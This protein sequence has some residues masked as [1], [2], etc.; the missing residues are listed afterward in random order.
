MENEK[1]KKEVL[2]LDSIALTYQSLKG[3]TP[4]INDVSLTVYE[5]EIV[6]IV[7]PSGCGKT[8]LLSI[9]AGLIKPSNGSVRIDNEPVTTKETIKNRVGYMF[10][11]DHLFEWRTVWE[12]VILAFEINKTKTKENL[13]RVERLLK[14]YGLYDFKDKHPRELSGG[15]RQRV[16]LIRTL[17]TNPSVLLLD[18]PFS[19]LDYQTRIKVCDDV[20][21]IIKNENKTAVLVTHDIAESICLANKVVVLTKRPSVIKST[22]LIELKEKTFL[23][24]RSETNFQILFDKVWEELQDEGEK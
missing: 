20:Y 24:R 13:E 1:G 16:A 10:Q 22:H 17:A 11:K 2:K 21:N 9:I 3:E 19:A 12:N 14:K 5:G 7:G 4:A 6:S 18:E 23:K 8:T 15:M